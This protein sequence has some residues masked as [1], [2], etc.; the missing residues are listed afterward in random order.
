[1]HTR[2]SAR[3]KGR[4]LRNSRGEMEVGKRVACVPGGGGTDPKG[5]VRGEV[6]LQG[7]R[8]RHEGPSEGV[9]LS[10][11]RQGQRERGV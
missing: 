7:A 1:M 4:R 6:G 8:E 11:G 10:E 9:V 3:G 5:E 2:D